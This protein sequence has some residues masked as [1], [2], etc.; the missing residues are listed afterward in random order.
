MKTFFFQAGE[1]TLTALGY[2][3]HEECVCCPCLPASQVC[4]HGQFVEETNIYH[5]AIS[6]L[7]DEY[8]KNGVV[9]KVKMLEQNCEKG[10]F[11]HS[12]ECNFQIFHFT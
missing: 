11:S 2:S 4:L 3:E 12:G 8:A 5:D 9:L 6:H 10:I 1:I 7:A